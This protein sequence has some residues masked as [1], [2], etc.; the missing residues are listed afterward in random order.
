MAKGIYQITEDFEKKLS[1]YTG[2][3]NITYSSFSFDTGSYYMG[4]GAAIG[5][6][7]DNQEILSWS[8]QF[9]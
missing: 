5:G 1:E 3:P 7:N 4:F 6:S 2:S 8:L 9:T